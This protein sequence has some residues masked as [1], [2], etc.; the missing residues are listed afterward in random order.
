LNK[1]IKRRTDVVGS[2]RNET[3]VLRLVARRC[4]SRTTTGPRRGT[5][6]VCRRWRRR[7]CARRNQCALRY[8]GA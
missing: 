6:W 2:F 3:S 7:R 5:T 4:S 1:E 8:L